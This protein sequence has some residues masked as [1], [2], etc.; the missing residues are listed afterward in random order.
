MSGT[1]QGRVTRV[2]GTLGQKLGYDTCYKE[3]N[4]EN[5]MLYILISNIS[6]KIVYNV[7][8]L[9]KLDVLSQERFYHTLAVRMVIRLDVI[10]PASVPCN[11]ENISS[12]SS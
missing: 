9:N 4:K 2:S 10:F 11:R 5:V 8:I 6:I 7:K 3:R 12:Q 1:D